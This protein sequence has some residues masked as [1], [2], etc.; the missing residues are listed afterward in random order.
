MTRSVADAALTLEAIAG[1]D[2]LDPRQPGEVPV[3]SYSEALSQGINGLRI[4]IL[5]EGFGT[6]LSEPDV[7]AAVNKAIGMLSELGA[8][9][10]NVSIPAHREAPPIV[11][12][13]VL[14]GATALVQS[15]GMGYHWEGL[16]NSSLAEALGKSRQAQSN[17]LPPTAKLFLL[18]GTYMQQH[19]HGRMYA[20]AQN[21]RSWLRA[22]YDRVFQDVDLLAMPTVPVKAYKNEPDVSVLEMVRHAINM[23]GNTAP[24]NQTGHPSITVPCGMSNGLPVGL[25][26]VGRHFEDA[27]VFRGA[28]AFEQQVNW[29]TF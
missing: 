5:T 15:N 22:S 20:K 8:V 28:H 11:M 13:L 7:D 9:T 1:K 29:E 21:L 18:L 6:G 16:Y 3:E 25:M 26:L 2:P 17:D 24:F 23:N 4:G 14:E 19:Y 10:S 12:S 27:T